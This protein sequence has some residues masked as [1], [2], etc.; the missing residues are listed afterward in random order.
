MGKANTQ[1]MI[2]ELIYQF[3]KSPGDASVI[4][5]VRQGDA[6]IKRSS[7]ASFR[8]KPFIGRCYLPPFFL[9]RPG[10]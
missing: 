2:A 4:L 6:H 5:D 10:Q 3:S 9:L 1:A 7:S 8:N